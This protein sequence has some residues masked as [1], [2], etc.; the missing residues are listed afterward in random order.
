MLVQILVGLDLVG[1]IRLVQ[2]EILGNL[3]KGKILKM[4]VII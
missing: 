1:R 2:S 3:P 4:Y